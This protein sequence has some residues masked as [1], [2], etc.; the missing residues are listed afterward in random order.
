MPPDQTDPQVTTQQA[1]GAA[2]TPAPAP[3]AGAPGQSADQLLEARL[4]GLNRLVNQQAAQIKDL[5][6]QLGGANTT[7]STFEKQLGDSQA[8]LGAKITGLT[9][10][11]TQLTQ[12]KTALEQ[13]AATDKAK[14]SKY[15]A[16]KKYPA[17]LPIADTIPD[18]PDAA[19][20]EQH[21]KLLSEGVDRI[22][23]D[24][25]SKLTMGL[26]P[27]PTTPAATTQYA[28]SSQAEWDNA[29]MSAAG[30]DQMEKIG[31]AYEAW[32]RSKH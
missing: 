17:L 29:L 3:A 24:K 2:V 12:A 30:T 27:G 8:A 18:I 32:L 9:D 31:A 13:A 6:T 16:L 5:E 15:E 7:A 11:V 20:M 22:A 1:G 21:L 10:Q 4:S 26:T 28:Y 14:L 25:A 23:Q 19:T